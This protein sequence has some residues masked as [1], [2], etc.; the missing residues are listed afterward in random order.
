MSVVSV[1]F[2]LLLASLL[3]LALLSSGLA[4][5]LLPSAAAAARPQVTGVAAATGLASGGEFVTLHGAGFLGAY[6][7]SFGSVKTRSLHVWSSTEITV[8]APAH[9]RGTVYVRVARPSS[10]SAASTLARYTYQAPTDSPGYL[11][12]AGTARPAPAVST[13]GEETQ[14]VPVDLSCSSESFCAAVGDLGLSTY[15]GTGWSAVTPTGSGST[16]PQV[17]C[18]NGFCMAAAADAHRWRYQ[19]GTWTDL[20]ALPGIHS[21]D[22]FLTTCIAEAGGQAHMYEDGAWRP[23]PNVLTGGVSGAACTR[24]ACVVTS[25]TGYFRSYSSVT[26]VWGGQRQMWNSAALRRS[27]LTAQVTG[28]LRCSSSDRCM[29]M[30]Q[31]DRGT[32]VQKFAL[33]T[34]RA[35][36]VGQSHRTT[37]GLPDGGTTRLKECRF[38]FSCLEVAYGT[39]DIGFQYRDWTLFNGTLSRPLVENRPAGAFNSISCWETYRCLGIANGTYQPVD[40]V[41]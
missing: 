21:L 13:V 18:S 31:P 17:S 11:R 39:D 28:D 6:V 29:S 15:D 35:W 14:E 40:D 10:A 33:F 26:G 22:C 19:N 3:S 25:P 7:V 12:P 41:S 24:N 38:A 32:G 4:A 2:R 16:R 20:G 30:G 27:A 5:G 23:G 1:P 8:R 9:H 36:S 34:G 37:L